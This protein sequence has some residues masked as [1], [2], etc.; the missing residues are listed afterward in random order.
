MAR[1]ALYPGTFD[2][3]TLG[4]LDVIRRALRLFDRVEVTLATNIAKRTLFSD[5]ER[6]D[7]IRQ[8]IA[9]W[10]AEERERVSVATFEG[11]VVEHARRR[12]AAALVR[13]LRQVS[14]FDYEMRMA[15][16]NRRLAEGVVTVFLTPSEE[17]A[18]TSAT[19]VREIHRFGGDVASFVPEP[20]RAALAARSARGGEG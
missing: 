8:S 9:G 4:H 19:L 16:A 6:A 15:V 14:D 20:V 12:G 2:P 10:P 17:H 7:L 5:D 13:G 18:F 1:L 11:L 3:V